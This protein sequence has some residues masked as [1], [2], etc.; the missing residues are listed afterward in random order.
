VTG[1][2]PDSDSDSDPDADATGDAPPDAGAPAPLV[3]PESLRAAFK[4]P[5]G[6][7]FTDAAALLAA[8]GRP[9]VAVG[10]V[11]TY[12]LL[13]AGHEP[14]VAVVDGRTKRRAVDPA[15][16]AVLG[17][18]ATEA[19]AD[20]DADVDADATPSEAGGSSESGGEST[21]AGGLRLDVRNEPGTVSRALVAA[22]AD[23]VGRPAPV[24]VRVDGEEDLATLPALLA[25]PPGAAVVYGQPDEGMVL[26][27]V[28]DAARSR[29]RSLL[30][31]MDG[32]ADAV[33]APLSASD[34]EAEESDAG[35]DAA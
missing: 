22:L 26:V 13:R 15:V 33:L 21:A 12:H 30:S 20:A 35:P 17:E 8:A 3:L 18:R 1:D 11:V 10:D 23:A 24:T 4:E 7:V 14:A 5:L 32:D 34:P 31:R 29:A 27:D 25:A 2:D 19:D 9:V 6:P 16:A 28:D